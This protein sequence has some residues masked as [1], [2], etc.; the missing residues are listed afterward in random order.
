MSD[1]EWQKLDREYERLIRECDLF[2]RYV[3]GLFALM[4]V[5]IITLIV[6][7]VTGVLP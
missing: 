5:G 4:A 6:L 1:D 2:L 7:A 3:G